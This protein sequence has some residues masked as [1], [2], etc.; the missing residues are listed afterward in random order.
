FPENIPA[1]PNTVYR[2]EG[3]VNMGDWL[4]TGFIATYDRTYRKFSKARAIAHSLGLKSGVEWTKFT[5]S[6]KLPNDIPAYPAKVYKGKGWEGMGDWL[7]SGYVANQARNYRPFIE[8]RLFARSLKLASRAR[9]REY[10]KA[11]MLPS[12]IPATPDRT[13]KDT[14]WTGFPDWLGTDYVPNKERTY[15]EFGL[16]RE[17]SRSLGLNNEKPEW[18]DFAKSGKLPP[19]IPASPSS[20]YKDRGWSGWK[21]WLSTE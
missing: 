17:Y 3:W 7:G 11:G 10:A 14:G 21:D 2:N 16:A 9:W 4:G 12:D 5:K 6:G 19:D 15:R 20:V 1:T 13:Y 8:A 18:R